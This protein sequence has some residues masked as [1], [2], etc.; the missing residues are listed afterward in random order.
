[1]EPLTFNQL[2]NFL[3]S[4][5]T[6]FILYKDEPKLEYIQEQLDQCHIP[7]EEWKKLLIPQAKLLGFHLWEEDSN[8]MLIPGYLYQF[9]PAGLELYSI[10]GEKSSMK[11]IP[12]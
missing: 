12:T 1:M 10:F 3:L 5:M 7:V 11:A 2:S 6:N 8:L 4:Q 9:I